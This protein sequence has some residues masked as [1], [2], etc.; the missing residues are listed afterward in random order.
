[1]PLC[2]MFE[3]RARVC[4][5]GGCVSLGKEEIRELAKR[6]PENKAAFLGG[7]ESRERTAN[8]KRREGRKKDRY[9][10]ELEQRPSWS[11]GRKTT[12]ALPREKEKTCPKNEERKKG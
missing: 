1:M 4:G 2:E 10:A 9:A 3:R 7:R 8:N 5:C 6:E 12:F 11:G